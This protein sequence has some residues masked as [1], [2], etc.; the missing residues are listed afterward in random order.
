[1]IIP[2]NIA[3]NKG[4]Y[5]EKIPREIALKPRALHD[6]ITLLLMTSLAK[7][8]ESGVKSVMLRVLF[9]NL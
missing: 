8:R 5:F 6:V 9:E 4:V 3:A 1:M 2:K 7:K